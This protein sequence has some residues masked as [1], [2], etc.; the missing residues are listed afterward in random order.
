[1]THPPPRP[2]A[3][4]T[5]FSTGTRYAVLSLVFM[6]EDGAYH[7]ARELAERLAFPL[8]YLAKVLKHLRQVGILESLRGPGGGFRLARSPQAITLRQ[9][10][11]AMEGESLAR[12]CPLGLRTCCEAMPCPFC[13]LLAPAFTQLMTQLTGLTLRDLSPEKGDKNHEQGGRKRFRILLS[14]PYHRDSATGI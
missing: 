11:M 10:V 14:F 3:P 12:L 2:H 4:R 7:M 1:M 8:P 5:P 9:V 13:I 6:A